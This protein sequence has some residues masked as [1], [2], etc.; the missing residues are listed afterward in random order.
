MKVNTNI[1]SGQVL[2]IGENGSVYLYTHNHADTLVKDV[3]DVLS[4]RLRWNDPDY[5][6][7]MIF[8]Q[9]V[10]KESWEDDIGYGIGTQFY[11]DVN[12]L[13]TLNFEHQ[14]VM[15]S[16]ADLKYPKYQMTFESFVSDYFKTAVL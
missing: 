1:N 2:I 7:R 8:C 16:S 15:I 12:V 10:L 4:R 11:V 9:M 5:L 3:H 13:I 14:T 6:T